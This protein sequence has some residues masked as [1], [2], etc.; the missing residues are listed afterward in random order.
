M[1]LVT[2]HAGAEAR[3]PE[4]L[5]YRAPTPPQVSHPQTSPIKVIHKYSDQELSDGGDGEIR[6][7]RSYHEHQP[8][9][10]SR[11]RR[12]GTPV[13]EDY[14]WYDKNGMRVRVREI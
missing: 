12:E 2:S 4:L 10:E 11:R 13:V 1:V 8:D 9:T 3:S 5:L 14:D 6:A 7:R